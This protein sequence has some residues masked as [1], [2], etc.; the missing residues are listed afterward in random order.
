LYYPFILYFI[1]L[2]YSITIINYFIYISTLVSYFITLL[3]VRFKKT[4]A[5]DGAD[6]RD[7]VSGVVGGEGMDRQNTRPMTPSWGL[8][9]WLLLFPPNLVF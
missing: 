2:Y 7:H 9:S 5:C 4:L 8:I 6:T 3:K 1:Y